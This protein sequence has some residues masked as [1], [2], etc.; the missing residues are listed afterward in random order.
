MKKYYIPADMSEKEKIIGGVLTII[1]LFWLLVGLVIGA[2][3]FLLTYNFIGP[4]LGLVL[5][6]IFTA[7]G[8]PF[9]FYTKQDLTFFQFLTL[10][11]KRK[12]ELKELKNYR[13]E[14]DEP[15]A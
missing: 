14:V 3:V 15:W 12:K 10:K 6:V 4:I 8:L 9:A 13:K 5:A 7:I 11:I 2:G 1:Q